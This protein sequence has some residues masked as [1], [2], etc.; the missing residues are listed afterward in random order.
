[1]AHGRRGRRCRRL[2]GL[3]LAT[4]ERAASP[5][6]LHGGREAVP[7]RPSFAAA[8]GLLTRSP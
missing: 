5:V 1:V 4:G 3:A 2:D 7:A 8:V 6:G